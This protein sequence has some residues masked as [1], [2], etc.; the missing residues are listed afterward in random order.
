MRWRDLAES[1]AGFAATVLKPGGVFLVKLFQGEETEPYL[2]MLRERFTS[3]AV[4][5]PAASRKQSTETYALARGPNCPDR[6]GRT[7]AGTPVPPGH[8]RRPA[9]RRRGAAPDRQGDD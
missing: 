3:V 6:S 4:R 2:R 1:A 5:K 8:G 9:R 7:G